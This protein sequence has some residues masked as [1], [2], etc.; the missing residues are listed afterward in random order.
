MP[1]IYK[2]TLPGRRDDGEI[3]WI[4]AN[5]L[6]ARQRSPLI[7]KTRSPPRV[8]QGNTLMQ[9]DAFPSPTRELFGRINDHFAIRQALQEEA[10]IAFGA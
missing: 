1:S 8:H 3:H 7:T 9:R 5:G 2:S 6:L 10:T 4:S